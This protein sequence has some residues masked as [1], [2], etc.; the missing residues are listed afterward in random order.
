MGDHHFEYGEVI[1]GSFDSCIKNLSASE[2]NKRIRGSLHSDGLNGTYKYFQM[3]QDFNRLY[4]YMI[5]EPYSF[6]IEN[7]TPGSAEPGNATVYPLHLTQ[8][9]KMRREKVPPDTNWQ[10]TDTIIKTDSGYAF[11]K[12]R[13]FDFF[14]DEDNSK[15][16]LY[17]F[18]HK[19]KAKGIESLSL[20]VRENDGGDPYSAVLLLGYLLDG[21]FRY[22]ASSS[23]FLYDDLKSVQ[24]ISENYFEGNLYILVDGGCYSTTGH[25]LS[26]L[27][28]HR[29]TIFIGEETGGSVICNGGFKEHR[30]PNTGIELLLPYTTFVA[31]ADGLVAGRGIMPDIPVGYSVSEIVSGADP[32]LP[33]AIV[34]TI[35]P[36]IRIAAIAIRQPGDSLRKIIPPTAASTGTM[37]WDTEAAVVVILCT[38]MYHKIYPTPEAITP[39]MIARPMPVAFS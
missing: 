13:F 28:S 31:E 30:L 8:I 23:T 5:G 21:P 9:R 36:M 39:D 35:P 7:L 11:L 17:D 22:F 1:C 18:F 26:I 6:N 29:K 10:L 16:L 27:N 3:N 24:P 19:I 20:D 34:I 4:L 2:I 33:A 38:I 14:E 12:V 25:F 15:A 32:V 37:S